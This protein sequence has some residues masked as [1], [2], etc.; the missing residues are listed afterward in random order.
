MEVTQNM[1]KTLKCPSESQKT[2][3]AKHQPAQHGLPDRKAANKPSF[4]GTDTD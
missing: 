1:I 3:A 2:N 4:L